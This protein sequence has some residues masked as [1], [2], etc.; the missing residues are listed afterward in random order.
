MLLLVVSSSTTSVSAPGASS[1]SSGTLPTP[2]PT[3]SSRTLTTAQR[4]FIVDSDL[5]IILL[6]TRT[7]AK[8]LYQVGALISDLPPLSDNPNRE[9]IGLN[10]WKKLIQD[11][12]ALG[13]RLLFTPE[14]LGLLTPVPYRGGEPVD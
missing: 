12:P 10:A 3:A 6:E 4:L 13:P 8:S 9:E 14:D 11:S 1:S 7:T 5:L 2:G